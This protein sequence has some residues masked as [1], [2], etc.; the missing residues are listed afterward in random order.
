MSQS[1]Q[2]DD[3]L[4]NSAQTEAQLIWE[5]AQHVLN[6]QTLLGELGFVEG[7]KVAGVVIAIRAGDR[8]HPTKGFDYLGPDWRQLKEA[9]FFRKLDARDNEVEQILREVLSKLE[10]NGYE[11]AI[12]YAR[13]ASPYQIVFL[14]SLDMISKFC[15]TP[16]V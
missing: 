16:D 3:W 2:D 8:L 11:S 5:Y 9:D 10:S 13:S 12:Q 4:T 14:L 6:N 15:D 7:S 1:F